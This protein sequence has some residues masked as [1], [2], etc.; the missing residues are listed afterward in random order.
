MEK[1]CG[2]Y[3]FYAGF[4][5]WIFGC[6]AWTQESFWHRGNGSK[7]TRYPYHTIHVWY[8]CLPLV[9]SCDKCRNI[10]LPVSWMVLHSPLIKL[11]GETNSLLTNKYKQPT[12]QRQHKSLVYSF[13]SNSVA[14]FQANA[15][16]IRHVFDGHTPETSCLG[17][18]ASPHAWTKSTKICSQKMSKKC[19]G[20]STDWK[21]KKRKFTPSKHWKW[22]EMGSSIGDS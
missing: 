12:N 10:N 8:M 3:V 21:L 15:P 20:D 4:L 13:Q 19:S 14:V 5:A 16:E 9:D 6:L 11:L 17:R 2:F 18:S 7:L 1:R 22:L